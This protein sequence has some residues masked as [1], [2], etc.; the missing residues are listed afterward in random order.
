MCPD[1]HA[2]HPSVLLHPCHSQS[3]SCEGMLC[4]PSLSRKGF[5]RAQ[6]SVLTGKIVN[7]AFSKHLCLEK[8]QQSSALL[9]SPFSCSV[10]SFGETCRSLG[11][12]PVNSDNRLKGEL[13]ELMFIPGLRIRLAFNTAAAAGI[14]YREHWAHLQVEPFLANP[15]FGPSSCVTALTHTL[16]RLSTFAGV[17]GETRAGLCLKCKST[18][19]GEGEISFWKVLSVLVDAGWRT[20]QVPSCEWKKSQI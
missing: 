1:F 10:L 20:E 8:S 11:I 2:S 15:A 12:P 18:G 4:S 3:F 9:F 16:G 17:S 5:G 6:E 19:P 13:D 14:Y 7:L